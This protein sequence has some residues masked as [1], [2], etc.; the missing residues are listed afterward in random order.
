MGKNKALAHHTSTY[1]H[2]RRVSISGVLL[3]RLTTCKR[4]ANSF[5]K[6]SL[7]TLP[8]RENGGIAGRPDI[9][10]DL[11]ISNNS[12]PKLN[13]ITVS[14]ELP[15]QVSEDLHSEDL[16]HPC[17]GMMR[18]TYTSRSHDSMAATAASPLVALYRNARYSMG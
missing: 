4:L 13:L 9:R 14:I 3:A 12:L 5:P 2:T 6:L 15:P 7:I 16:V 8:P 17:R 11:S 18:Y 10:A 1:F